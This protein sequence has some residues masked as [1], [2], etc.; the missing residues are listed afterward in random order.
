MPLTRSRAP[1]RVRGREPIGGSGRKT[2][3]RIAGGRIAGGRD[4]NAGANAGRRVRRSAR[5]TGHKPGGIAAP[6]DAGE[7]SDLSIKNVPSGGDASGGIGTGMASGSSSEGEEGAG[8]AGAEGGDR[9]VDWMEDVCEDEGE[10]S[11][12]EELGRRHTRG[13]RRAALSRSAGPS[14]RGRGVR[15]RAAG[16]GRRRQRE[17]IRDDS[18]SDDSDYAP[19]PS[20]EEDVED[21]EDA[22]VM[23]VM[24]AV[25]RA[26][27]R[28]GEARDVV[29][30]VSRDS[31]SDGTVDEVPLAARAVVR[32]KG[33][34]SGRSKRSRQSRADKRQK[35]RRCW[36]PEKPEI[37]ENG[38][39]SGDLD[40]DPEALGWSKSKEQME[41]SSELLMPLLPFQKEFLAWAVKQEHGPLRGGVLA[42]EMGM[43]KTIQAIAV[44]LANPIVPARGLKTPKHQLAA[45]SKP[46]CPSQPLAMD[47][48]P[49]MCVPISESLP[50]TPPAYTAGMARVLDDVAVSACCGTTLVVCPLVAVIQWRQE[51]ARFTTPGALKVLIYHGPKRTTSQAELEEADVVLTTYSILENEYRKSEMP[52]KVQCRYCGKKFYPDR[53]KVHL[54]Y[55]CGP[56]AVKSTALA[57]QKRKTVSKTKTIPSRKGM[58]SSSKGFHLG[59]ESAE[60]AG[61]MGGSVK[62]L[63]PN[64]RHLF[65]EGRM[66]AHEQDALDM[67][68]EATRDKGEDFGKRS[69]SLLH[70][71]CW[72][73]IV[74]DEAHSIKERRCNTAHAAFALKSKYK[75]ALSGTPLQN[76]VA[77]LYSLIRFIRTYPY[78]YYF[79][80][81]CDCKCIDYP[82]KSNSRQCRTCGHSPLH[83]FCWWNK[84]VANPIKRYGYSSAGKLA[85]AVLKTEILDRTLLRRTKVQCADDLALPP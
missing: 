61:M 54:R 29:D 68:L 64:L 40:L 30:L 66:W 32:T 76:R 28:A 16:A 35:K 79:C 17:L 72:C 48:S 5:L 85:M 83:H 75:W 45:M 8:R 71:I 77:E 25:G 43:G 1:G 47:R 12:S 65:D 63:P 46:G 34:V 70:R 67:I 22:K 62:D 41:P 10:G 59:C 42:D 58:A 9:G 39:I 18:D 60:E 7:A 53:L 6:A 11:G 19:E 44:I 81:K 26:W 2:S 73:R 20:E 56:N 50:T 55:F 49:A 4:P 15:A 80:R 38:Y 3:R 33:D 52:S 24:G 51:I 37:F 13:C 36:S 69:G 23:K 78:S 57:K 82:F 27:G 74:L 21:E 31:D 14:R 84:Y